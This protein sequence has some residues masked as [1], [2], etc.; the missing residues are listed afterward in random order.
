MLSEIATRGL[1]QRNDCVHHAL[2]EVGR[3]GRRE[4][5]GR[6]GRREL[7]LLLDTIFSALLRA[8]QSVLGHYDMKTTQKPSVYRYTSLPFQLMPKPPPESSLFCLQ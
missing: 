5:V 4:E 7:D 6:F 1:I 3:F 8:T 2:F